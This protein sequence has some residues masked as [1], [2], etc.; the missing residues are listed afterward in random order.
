MTQQNAQ[1]NMPAIVPAGQLNFFD[2]TVF[3][4]V[5]RLARMYSNSELVPD[6]YRV[7]DKN[8]EQKAISNT[9]IAMDIAVRLNANLLMVMQNMT[10][11]YGKPAWASKFLIAMIN[12]CG[13]YEKLEYKWNDLGE[14]QNYRYKEYENSYANGKKTTSVVEKVFTGPIRNLE[15]VAFTTE[16]ATKKLLESPPVS[17]KLAI[18]EGWYTKKGSKWP[19]MTNLMLIYRAAS[20]WA[21]VHAPELSMGIKTIEEVRDVED[22]QFEDVTNNDPAAKKVKDEIREKAN[23]KELDLDKD[24]S[25]EPGTPEPTRQEEELQE[26]KF[27]SLDDLRKFLNNEC[28]VHYADMIRD[29]VFDEAKKQ[30]IKPVITGTPP[31][32][33]F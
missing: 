24:Q 26:V 2:P 19:T 13:K 28:G 30:G 14:I 16:K 21:S 5:Q 31:T 29:K 32:P 25:P 23:K 12:S 1:S 18:D 8:S 10:P 17:V 27:E 4:Q 7:S 3:E 15:C 22:A 6:M 20:Q 33:N 11:I 9:I